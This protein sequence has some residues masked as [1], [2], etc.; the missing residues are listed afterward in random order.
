MSHHNR[1]KAQIK[2]VIKKIEK[3]HWVHISPGFNYCKNVNVWKKRN[4][5][6]TEK[7]YEI[8]VCKSNYDRVNREFIFR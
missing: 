6:A 4:G 3:R 5:L 2:L 8:R 1:F 7:L